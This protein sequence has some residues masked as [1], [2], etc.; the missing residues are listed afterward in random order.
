MRQE[1]PNSKY[2]VWCTA[3]GKPIPLT[4][5]RVRDDISK[6][7]W[8]MPCIAVF[9]SL[10]ADD[11]KKC[12][13]SVTRDTVIPNTVTPSVT[14]SFVTADT[15]MTRNAGTIGDYT[16]VVVNAY[17][18]VQDKLQSRAKTLPDAAV[19]A[20]LAATACIQYFRAGGK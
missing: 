8:C 17:V 9:D 15:L 16:Q 11:S 3:C 7:T 4:D 5:P 1:W 12:T 14:P 13:P 6:Q 10:E 2:K 20:S 18:G 19:I